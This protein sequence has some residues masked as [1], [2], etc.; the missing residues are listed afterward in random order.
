VD[1]GDIVEDFVLADDEGRERSLGALL[2]DGPVVLF[3]YPAALSPGCTME[4]CHFRDL[5]AE[6]RA[7][8]GQPVGVSGDAV[9]RQAEFSARHSLGYP[10]LSD[11]DGKVREM[12][13]IN[14]SFG[15]PRRMTF[16]IDTDRRVLAVV[17]SEIRMS[18]HADKALTA[19]QQRARQ[20]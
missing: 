5:T 20:G 6:L 10:L 19:L 17:K 7:A 2:E 15:L 8:G 1:V 12:F 11:E 3:F 4:A 13:G 14:R 9:E 16:V 18:V